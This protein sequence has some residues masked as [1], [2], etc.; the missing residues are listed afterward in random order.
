[1]F[2]CKERRV[3]CRHADEGGED[4]KVAGAKIYA[5]NKSELVGYR[6]KDSNSRSSGRCQN[7]GELA[8]I[9]SGQVAQQFPSLQ[10]A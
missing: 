9:Q 2:E 8:Q 5:G 6:L 10:S 3:P 7:L 1:M 4:R